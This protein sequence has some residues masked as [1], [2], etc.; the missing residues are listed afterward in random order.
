MIRY[1]QPPGLIFQAEPGT[2]IDTHLSAIKNS[3]AQKDIYIP[4]AGDRKA[5]IPP[6]WVHIPKG[7]ELRVH[8]YGYNPLWSVV[9]L[10]S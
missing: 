5:A 7:T 4:R 2:Q 8:P 9:S 3:I 10:N 1:K 6:H